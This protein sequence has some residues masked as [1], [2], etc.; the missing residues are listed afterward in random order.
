[1]KKT[2][3]IILIFLSIS[4]L[5]LVG[6]TNLILKKVVVSTLEDTL[7]KK[8]TIK[9]LWLNPFTGVLTSN[10][11]IFWNKEK[12]KL[13][14]LHS[15]KINTDPLKLFG[16][17]LSISE[18]R[19]IEPTLNLISLGNN[20]KINKENLP[21]IEK[22][23]IKMSSENFIN[24]IEI[25]NITVEKLTF[26][27]TDKIIKSMDTITFKVPNFTYKNKKLDLSGSLN[28]LGSGLIDIK[29]KADTKTGILE[30][31]LVSEGFE[32]SNSFFPDK[33]NEINLTGSLKGYL[34]V[35]G[36]YLKK[37]FQVK[38]SVSGSNI[39]VENKKGNQFLNSKS[40][41]VDLEK[42]TFPKISLNLKKL[43]IEDTKGNLSVFSKEKTAFF[44]EEKQEVRSL[45]R[46]KKN[47]LFK[48]INIGE[49]AIKSSS[50]TYDD[51]A[52][53]NI[54]LNIKNIKNIPGNKGSLFTSFTFN[55]SM[56]FSSKSLVEILNYSKEF[57][58]LKDI[59]LKGNFILDASSLDLPESI[60]NKGSY[61][62]ETKKINLKSNYSF[63]YPNLLLKSDVFIEDLKFIGKG[64]QLQ[65]LLTKSIY[66]NFSFDYNIDD[67]SY[68][69]SGPLNF[70]DLNIKNKENKNFFLGDIFLELNSLD[71]EKITLDSVVLNNF[72]LDLN[73]K[74]FPENPEKL[75]LEKINPQDKTLPS[76]DREIKVQIDNLKL[77]NGQFLIKD[78]SLKKISLDGSNISN[79]NIDSNFIFDALIDDSTPIKGDLNLKLK[80]INNFSDLQTKGDISIS[81]LNLEILKPYI[82][83]LPYEIKGDID[84]LSS[85]NYSK[86]SISSK[87]NFL[88]SDL[89][90]KKDESIEISIDKIQ[91]KLNFNLKKDELS[92]S[93][94]NFLISNFKGDI[95]DKTKIE[96]TKGDIFVEKYSP[97]TIKFNSIF[98]TSPKIE[99]KESPQI[100]ENSQGSDQQQKEEKQP[101][102]LIFASKINIEGGKIIYK[103][104][105]KTSVYDNIEFSSLNFT[106]QK[107][108]TFPID[109]GLSLSGIEKIELKGDLT[110]KEDW[111]FSPKTITF[112]GS[113]DL[114][115]LNIP[116]FNNFLENNLPNK[117][118]SGIL[119]S[120]GKINLIDGRL[121]SDHNITISKIN[122]GEATGYSKLVPLESIIK[123][124]SDKYGDININLPITGNL[125]DPKLGI[126]SII[127]SS[128]ISGL[129][130]TAKSPQ[131]IVSKV[132]SLGSE[133][134]NTIYFDYLSPKPSKSEVD[135]LNEIKKK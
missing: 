57:N 118:N 42:L 32:Y 44:S 87:G 134:I 109:A 23:D 77:R 131:N 59:V 7:N 123:V 107:N 105:K 31:F 17:K 13:L 4:I 122:L 95:K 8:V 24:E 10:D 15:I 72:F 18:I 104:L 114:K 70:E 119:S 5:L 33:E 71:K 116:L 89:Y 48:D 45:P 64:K 20:Q 16:R 96:I 93:K 103:D 21:Q 26:I 133:E 58:F 67:S 40:I 83:D 29:I 88:G 53:T 97:K 36:N 76:K 110:L 130:K 28:I 52:F 25:K 81:N 30:T 113:L 35:E 120:S 6:G 75:N 22:K 47:Y 94:S 1:M 100:K 125:T 43:E 112:N 39:L 60:K 124:L 102:P 62:P 99:L 3:K 61:S 50:L 41:V 90:I 85:F 27:K 14:S 98:L 37:E 51:L 135:K 111:D 132:L 49:I 129:I 84:L 65:D 73:T 11:V 91:S 68:S 78:L 117:F 106:T 63:S 80:N 9:G 82:K 101:L 74:I 56:N 69:L 12:K 108:K 115:K 38:G 19:L 121:N 128:I 79:K 46:K 54:N 127:T 126:T 66:G 34:F 55:D 92:L 86:D 2:Y